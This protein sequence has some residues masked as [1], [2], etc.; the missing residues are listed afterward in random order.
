MTIKFDPISTDDYYG[1]S[2]ILR[3]T[4]LENR[5]LQSAE[6]VSLIEELKSIQSQIEQVS[7]QELKRLRSVAV[8][9][10]RG[11]FGSR[12]RSA[13]MATSTGGVKGR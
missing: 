8:G 5:P 3:S 13:A 10:K 7:I 11:L 9:E 2:G 12:L 4:K 6:T 1:L